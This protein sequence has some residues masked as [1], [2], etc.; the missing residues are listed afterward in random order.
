VSGSRKDTQQP[1]A[2]TLAN[3]ASAVH[4]RTEVRDRMFSKQQDEADFRNKSTIPAPPATFESLRPEVPQQP[5]V[6]HSAR[7]GNPSQLS[8]VEFVRP[9]IRAL[10]ASL[11]AAERRRLLV[12][13]ISELD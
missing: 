6:R 13:L 7:P 10:L 9:R 2:E 3:G 8:E 1:A 5:A 11:S 12:E 4:E